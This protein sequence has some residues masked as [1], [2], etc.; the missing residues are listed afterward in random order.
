VPP[1]RD[2]ATRRARQRLLF[3]AFGGAGVTEHPSRYPVPGTYRPRVLG[4]ESVQ[5]RRP[6]TLTAA[7]WCQLAV[8]GLFVLLAAVGVAVAVQLTRQFTD[9]SPAFPAGPIGWSLMA[10]GLMLALAVWL[11][12]SAAGLRRRSRAGYWLSLTGLILPP[13]AVVTAGVLGPDT[14]TIEF[15]AFVA[16]DE[17]A[18]A[19]ALADRLAAWATTITAV[20]ALTA[21]VLIVT[22][23]GLLLTA[24]SRQ[25][26]A[27]TAQPGTPQ[28]P[29][30]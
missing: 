22:A 16:G 14:Y 7:F 15:A 30:H 26:F 3:S 23:V 4:E 5:D 25:H 18:D 13:L 24:A 1:G 9:V 29:A 10:A 12:S 28:P 11:A 6:T 19:A 2:P 21:F 20:V 8:A 27:G 17:Q